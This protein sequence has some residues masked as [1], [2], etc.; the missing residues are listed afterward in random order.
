M[1]ALQAFAG[2]G[3]SEE[4]RMASLYLHSINN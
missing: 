4:Q 3:P 2:Q 1:T